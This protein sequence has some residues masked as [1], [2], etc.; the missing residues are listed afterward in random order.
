M[1][2]PFVSGGHRSFFDSTVLTLQGLRPGDRVHYTLDGTRPG[3]LSQVYQDPVVLKESTPLRMIAA[4]SSGSLQSGEVTAWFGKIPAQVAVRYIIPYAAMYPAN[5]DLT[6]IDGI[7]GG[8]NFRTGDWQGFQEEGPDVVIDLGR[9][10]HL[11]S[12]SAG[13]LQDAGSWIWMPSEVRFLLS[14]DGRSFREAGRVLTDVPEREY[15]GITR[16]MGC[17][18]AARKARYIRLQATGLGHC[19]AWHPG[20]PYGG[21]AWVFIDE[22]SWRE[23]PEPSIR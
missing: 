16:E 2:V 10:M 12:L 19:P 18:F 7:R 21:K 15:G 11:D 8:N 1:P 9:I 14:E 23:R 6:L 3:L 17:R 4:D 13:F 5:G 20:Y 22:L